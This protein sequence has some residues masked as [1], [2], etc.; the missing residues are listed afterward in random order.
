M[1]NEAKLVSSGM[2]KIILT[3]WNQELYFC[4]QILIH[5]LKLGNDTIRCFDKMNRQPRFNTLLHL[6]I[7]HNNMLQFPVL[8]WEMVSSIWNDSDTKRL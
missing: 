5:V 7:L 4:Q 2:K 3:R 1:Q 6:Y 8:C